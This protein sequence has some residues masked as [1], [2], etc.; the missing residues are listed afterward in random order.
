MLI[1]TLKQ[2]IKRPGKYTIKNNIKL[3]E[4]LKNVKVNRDTKLYSFVISNMYT[5]IPIDDD[6]NIIINKL[7]T[8]NENDIYLKQLTCLIL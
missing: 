5:N 2:N 1:Q 4:Q 6:I 7:K 8:H 3:T